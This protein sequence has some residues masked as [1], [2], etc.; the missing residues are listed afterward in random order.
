M[1]DAGARW[2]PILITGLMLGLDLA[3]VTGLGLRPWSLIPPA[4]ALGFAVAGPR[5][6]LTPWRDALLVIL[7]VLMLA[8]MFV[9]SGWMRDLPRE[10]RWS[11]GTFSAAGIGLAFVTYLHGDGLGARM[12]RLAGTGFGRGLRR[13]FHRSTELLML[14]AALGFLGYAFAQPGANRTLVVVPMVLVLAAL[15]PARWRA[16]GQGV[17]VLGCLPLPILAI[18]GL[19]GWTKPGW[20]W[21]LLLSGC[22][23]D[24]IGKLR[25]PVP[26]STLTNEAASSAG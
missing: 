7:L 23:A 4:L 16:V 17:Q 5:A 13:L 6:R 3:M 2:S 1:T 26:P 10:D 25:A 15:L 24:A 12:R 20:F 19:M 21:L 14:F 22:A 11:L 8:R 18:G 9:P